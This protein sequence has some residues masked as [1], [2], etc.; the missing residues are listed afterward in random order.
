MT[1]SPG[2]WERTAA[3]RMAAEARIGVSGLITI[4]KRHRSLVN[5]PE[6]RLGQYEAEEDAGTQPEDGD[7]QVLGRDQPRQQALAHAFRSQ[8]GHLHAPLGDVDGDRGVDEGQGHGRPEDDH[9]ADHQV[10][11]RHVGLERLEEVLVLLHRRNPV[12]S[13]QPG[14]H[15][16][17]HRRVAE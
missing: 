15:P 17:P 1:R 3:R 12:E 7:Q 4:S 14:P 10:E 2:H 13:G 16:R 5:V 11:E 9:E 6:E 8:R